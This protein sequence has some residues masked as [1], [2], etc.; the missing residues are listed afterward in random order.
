MEIQLWREILDPYELAVKELVIKF[1][2]L[3]KEHR[4]NNRYSPIEQVEGRVKTISSILEKSLKKG[5]PLEDIEEKI[6]DIAGIRII[7]QFVEDIDRVVELIRGRGDME[8]KSEK[9]YLAH[10]KESGYRSYHVIV[11]YQVETINGPK[12]L[13]VEIQIRTLAMNFWA[14]IEHSLQYKYEKNIPEHIRKRLSAAAD[15]VDMLDNEMSSVRSEIMDA[16]NSFQIQANIV[17]DILNNIENLYKVL[18]KREIKKIQDE[19]YQI[20]TMNDLNQLER[21][22]KQL[23]QVAEG[24]RAQ[25]LSGL[26]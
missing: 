11:Y 1:K 12:K 15:A 8:I 17:A 14:I 5:I 6:E 20:Y 19:F 16:Q 25:A 22:D 4:D 24:Y 9:N 3:I 21:F 10:S 7:C 13:Q 23:D 2:H 18:N 26:R